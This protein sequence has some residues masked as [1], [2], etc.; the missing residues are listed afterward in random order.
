MATLHDVMSMS[1]RLEHQTFNINKPR[2]TLIAQQ[3]GFIHEEKGFSEYFE[4]V[5]GWAH[6]CDNSRA[7][8]ITVDSNKVYLTKINTRTV[9]GIHDFHKYT[10][11]FRFPRP[12]VIVIHSV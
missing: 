11:D 3:I 4:Q 8:A 9:S 7:N 12:F 2:K 6:T 10:N 1:Y 5:D